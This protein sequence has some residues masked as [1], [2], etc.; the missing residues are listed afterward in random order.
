MLKFTMRVNSFHRL[1]WDNFPIPILNLFGRTIKTLF[2][3]DHIT[4][5]FENQIFRSFNSEMLAGESKSKLIIWFGFLSGTT[6][7][8][9]ELDFLTQLKTSLDVDLIAVFNINHDPRVMS[10]GDDFPIYLRKNFGRDLGALRD[11]LQM[12]S[13]SISKYPTICVLNSSCA[14]DISKISKCLMAGDLDNEVTFLTD[15]IQGGHHI[16]SYFWKM[17]GKTAEKLSVSL[18]SSF[19]NWKS[20]R[21]T[22]FYGEKRVLKILES[23]KITFK[24]LYPWNLLGT[25]NN[26][27]RKNPSI[28]F[29][30]RLQSLGCPGIKKI[31]SIS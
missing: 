22:V 12:D 4:S 6:F 13:L 14:W 8:K 26:M 29:K 23:E 31:G 15:S 17:N 2:W 20:K 28:H 1:M 18:K 16:Q 5:N 7:D 27:K 19:K 30:S 24:I 3:I 21:A 10:V 9:S 25:E 11:V